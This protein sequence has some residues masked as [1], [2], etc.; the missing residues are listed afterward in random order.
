MA[1]AKNTK[2]FV[3]NTVAATA[4]DLSIPSQGRVKVT[5]DTEGFLRRDAS[6]IVVKKF[7]VETL[8]VSAVT[9]TATPVA[10]TTYRFIMEQEDANGDIQRLPVDYYAGT[11]VTATILGT[12]ITASVQAHIDSG[13]LQATA[14]VIT[15]GNGGVTITALTGYPVIRF[16]QPIAMTVATSL[17]NRASSGN[18]SRSSLVLT[19]LEGDTSAFA[20]GQLVKLT[21]WTGGATL[22]GKTATEGVILRVDSIS[23]N[24]NVKYVIEAYVGTIS[25]AV[26]TFEI[27]ATNA[28]GIGADLTADRS[29]TGGGD[30]NVDIVAANVYHEVI[31]T[32]GEPSGS[33]MTVTDFAP[34]ESHYFIS[35]TGSA[36]NALLLTDR[37][38][39]VEQYF[40]AGGTT[41]DPALL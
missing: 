2:Y 20:V 18:L 23:A 4:G 8:Q 15:S 36:S 12:A 7:I 32:A 21:G 10:G 31:V 9:A 40:V 27:L 41:V 38:E 34:F 25:A 35:S 6:S 37:F 26:C 17:E 28:T 24:T 3:I 14:V 33:T 11:G 30:P 29:I 39:E 22:N 1:T 5:G 19:M 13:K 16:K